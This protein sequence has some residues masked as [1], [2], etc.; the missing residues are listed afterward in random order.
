MIQNIKKKS[1]S[2]LISF[3]FISFIFYGASAVYA[4][5]STDWWTTANTFF[6]SKGTGV[7][8]TKDTLTDI[9]NIIKIF[10]N[11]VI[12]SVTVFLGIKYMYGSAE[13]KGD[14]KEGLLTLFVAMLFFYGGTTIYDIFT[15]SNGL[16]FVSQT[17]ADATIYNVY[18]GILYIAKIIAFAGIIYVGIRYLASGAEGKAELKGKGVPF[19]IGIVMTFGTLSFLEF[20]RTVIS[21]ILTT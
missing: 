18:S 11:G 4:A 1:V 3:M 5:S 19:F 14:V 2:I 17:S 21:D 7:V 9:V 20:M 15:T 12:I 10:G 6:N 8:D 13:G 16:I